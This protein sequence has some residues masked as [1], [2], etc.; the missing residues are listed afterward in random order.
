[1]Q[2]WSSKNVEKKMF[3]EWLL[4]KDGLISSSQTVSTP[5]SEP[6]IEI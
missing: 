1:M 2:E 5:Y 3:T 6:Y 4:V